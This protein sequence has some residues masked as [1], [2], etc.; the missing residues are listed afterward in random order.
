MLVVDVV[1]LVVGSLLDSLELR[2]SD[3]LHSLENF[4]EIIWRAMEGGVV[5]QGGEL[6][7]DFLAP[8]RNLVVNNIDFLV[9]L[10]EQLV[11]LLLLLDFLLHFNYVLV[12]EFAA[13]LVI[14][15]S[16]GLGINLQVM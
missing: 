14:I 15:S 1:S 4:D 5:S 3:V 13:R 2:H 9:L 10:L 12:M 6:A 11:I 16:I 8:A 7:V